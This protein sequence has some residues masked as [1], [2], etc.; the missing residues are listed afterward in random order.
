[1][2]CTSSMAMLESELAESAF[3]KDSKAK[4][5]I[6]RSGK[7]EHFTCEEDLLSF[8]TKACSSSL[9]SE[10][11]MPPCQPKGTATIEQMDALSLSSWYLE[12]TRVAVPAGLIIH[13][14]PD[15]KLHEKHLNKLDSSSAQHELE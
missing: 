1:M 2:G 14:A 4:Q 3:F 8:S 12:K 15:R 10:T 9:T 5:M 6:G 13:H 7:D 11:C